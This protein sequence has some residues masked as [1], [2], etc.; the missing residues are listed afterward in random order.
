LVKNW[1]PRVREKYFKTAIREA[2]YFLYPNAKK[3]SVTMRTNRREKFTLSH[4]KF[5]KISLNAEPTGKKERST[6]PGIDNI[7]PFNTH[8][9][10]Q[11]K[12][13]FP[14]ITAP[15]TRRFSYIVYQARTWIQF[16]GI[17]E[18]RCVGLGL[19]IEKVKDVVLNSEHFLPFD[20]VDE[21][22]KALRDIWSWR[23][24]IGRD[25]TNRGKWNGIIWG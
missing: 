1:D 18:S 22:A 3:G 10:F 8:F 2:P 6:H 11:R 12:T 5:D 14:F 25:G 17:R 4:P 7:A 24:S 16:R 15:A 21:T 20:M 9:M 19:E 23:L 13:C